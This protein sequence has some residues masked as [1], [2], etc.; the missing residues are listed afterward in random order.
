MRDDEPPTLAFKIEAVVI[1][2]LMLAAAGSFVVGLF[3]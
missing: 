1:A 3:R 2:L